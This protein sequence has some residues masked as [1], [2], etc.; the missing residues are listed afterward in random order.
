[1][2]TLEQLTELLALAKAARLPWMADIRSGIAAV[3]E[4]P[5]RNC[6]DL[7]DRAFVAVKHGT[8]DKTSHAWTMDPQDSAKMVYVAA[9][10]NAVPEL[11]ERLLV[12]EQALE[13]ASRDVFYAGNSL[14]LLTHEQQ[15]E[16]Y[17]GEAR[18]ALNLPEEGEPT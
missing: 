8:C 3:Y 7:P 16:H 15:V 14:S 1:M 13:Q 9:A 6:L 12:A 10:C 17:L 2:M 18:T 5:Q 4:P 11:V